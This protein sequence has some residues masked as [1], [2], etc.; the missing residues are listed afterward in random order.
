MVPAFPKLP[1]NASSMP[2]ANLPLCNDGICATFA[3]ETE[4]KAVISVRVLCC[5]ELV[6]TRI[7]ISALT[8]QD[9]SPVEAA[10]S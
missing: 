3:V 1:Y 8:M 7:V 4:I 10:N 5:S 6:P 9:S 2:A